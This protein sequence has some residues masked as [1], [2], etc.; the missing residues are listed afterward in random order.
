MRKNGIICLA[1]VFVLVA[2]AAPSSAQLSPTGKAAT[3]VGDG[4]GQ[5]IEV[6]GDVP[7]AVEI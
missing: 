7:V 6:N 1:F 2:M 4:Y 3:Q 5:W